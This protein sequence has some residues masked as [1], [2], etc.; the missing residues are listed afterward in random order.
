MSIDRH[1]DLFELV[2]DGPTIPIHGFVTALAHLVKLGT[3]SNL[4]IVDI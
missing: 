2:P 1:K 4:V 3:V